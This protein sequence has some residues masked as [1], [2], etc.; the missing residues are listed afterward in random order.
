[1]FTHPHS[2]AIE[3]VAIGGVLTSSKTRTWR[4]LKPAFLERFPGATFFE[5]VAAHCGP[6]DYGALRSLIDRVVEQYGNSDKQLILMGLSAGTLVAEA[7][8]TRMRKADIRLIVSIFGPHTTFGPLATAWLQW[9]LGLSY[10][11]DAPVISFHGKRDIVVPLGSRHPHAKVHEE[12]DSDH[13]RDL[14]VNPL[15]AKRIA[16]IA[17]EQFRT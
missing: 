13:Q 4:H 5:E 15:L 9:R 10:Q 8:A 1:M 6:M 17:R 2:K 3:I 14:M 11:K 16:K 7:A 12:L